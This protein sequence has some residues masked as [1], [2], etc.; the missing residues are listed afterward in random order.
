MTERTDEP[1]PELPY[2]GICAQGHPARGWT[3]APRLTRAATPRCRDPEHT[4]EPD[5][6]AF[7]SGCFRAS[8][9]TKLRHIKAIRENICS[10][11]MHQCCWRK[12]RWKGARCLA[13]WGW[14]MAPA[15]VAA[16]QEIKHRAVHRSHGRWGGTSQS[17]GYRKPS[18]FQKPELSSAY[19]RKTQLVSMRISQIH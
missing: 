18:L 19:R 17:S 8:T 5:T 7:W 16:D 11:A 10:S 6:R 3:L 14:L 12:I 9:G 2:T 4:H 13:G 15:L 1:L